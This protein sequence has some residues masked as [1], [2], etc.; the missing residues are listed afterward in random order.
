MTD[1]IPSEP[2][3]RIE[4]SG[5]AFAQRVVAGAHVLTADEPAAAGGTDSGPTPYQLLLAALG[6]CTSMT[7]GLYARRKQWPVERI[8]VRLNQSRVHATDCVACESKE[9]QIYRIEREIVV[10]GPLSDEQR[11][12]LLEIAERCPVHRTLTG[13]I[14]IVTRLG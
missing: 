9:A 12:R 4:G 1:S 8:E 3:V 11:Q 10:A 13:K 14:E 6:S 2:V 7:I 5:A